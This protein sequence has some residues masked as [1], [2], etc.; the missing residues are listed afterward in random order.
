M[1]E[2]GYKSTDAVFEEK[3][4]VSYSYTI[5]SCVQTTIVPTYQ[6]RTVILRQQ[7]YFFMPFPL[8]YHNKCVFGRK[9]KVGSPM[10]SL[11]LSIPVSKRANSLSCRTVY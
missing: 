7:N 4:S 8:V 10:L 2:I 11:N 6:V 3:K 1:L 9:S 5:G